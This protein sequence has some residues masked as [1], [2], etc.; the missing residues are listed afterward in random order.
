MPRHEIILAGNLANPI[1]ALAIRA[2]DDV[3]LLDS[4]ANRMEHAACKT[5]RYARLPRV[6]FK[7]DGNEL[8]IKVTPILSEFTRQIR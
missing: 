3:A 7:I 8:G 5:R 6:C 2:E 1:G 4:L